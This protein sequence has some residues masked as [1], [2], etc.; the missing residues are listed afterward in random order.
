[1]R[2]AKERV[3]EYLEFVERAGVPSGASTDDDE[4]DPS[5]RGIWQDLIDSRHNPCGEKLVAL[6]GDMIGI[7]KTHAHPD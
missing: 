4:G 6:A 7:E 5:R 2:V 1:M 3:T